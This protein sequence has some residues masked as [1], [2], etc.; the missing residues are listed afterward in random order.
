MLA[1]EHGEEVYAIC[2]VE[3]SKTI[4]VEENGGDTLY[5][6]MRKKEK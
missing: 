6:A 4:K 2:C 3:I 5:M 1:K